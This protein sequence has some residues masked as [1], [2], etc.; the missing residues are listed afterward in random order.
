MK[1]LI[2]LILLIGCGHAFD[3]RQIT[4]KS[5]T[6]LAEWDRVTLPIGIC[7]FCYDNGARCFIDSCKY[8]YVLDTIG[9]TK[10]R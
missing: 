8:Y 7:C 3:P 5:N 6:R 9:V 4:N 2:I 1:Y 10:R